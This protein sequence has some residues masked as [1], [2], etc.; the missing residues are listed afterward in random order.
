MNKKLKTGS[1]NPGLPYAWVD[2]H[3]QGFDLLKFQYICQSRILVNYPPHSSNGSNNV[4]TNILFALDYSEVSEYL[5][6]CT[7][8]MFCDHGNGR[9]FMLVLWALIVSV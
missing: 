3:T 5:F 2:I 7:S 6:L 9:V 1:F 8:N 4:F